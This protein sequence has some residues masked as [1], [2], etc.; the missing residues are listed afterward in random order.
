LR[1]VHPCNGGQVFDSRLHLEFRYGISLLDL[2][3][4]IQ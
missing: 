3:D 2:A 1:M 4:T